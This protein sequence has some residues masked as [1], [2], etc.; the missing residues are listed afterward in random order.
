MCG[1][2]TAAYN[3]ARNIGGSVGVALVTT[4][5]ARRSQAHQAMLTSHVDLW[6]PEVTGRL[7]MWTD[8]FVTHGADTFTAS[9]QALAMLYRETVTQ[10]HIL[11]YAD[12]FWLLLAVYSSVLLLI[13]FMRRVRSGQ[14]ARRRKSAE[15][16]SVARDPGLPA[17][18]E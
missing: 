10:A 3:V 1:L 11:S 4:L 9:R 15:D 12:D 5:L 17:P 16:E 2:A 14:A 6:N 18:A 8:H 13:P 7:R